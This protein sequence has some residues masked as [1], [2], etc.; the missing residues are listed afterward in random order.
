MTGSSSDVDLSDKNGNTDTVKQNG[1]SCRSPTE[2][3]AH[4]QDPVFFFGAWFSDIAIAISLRAGAAP[5]G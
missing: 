1:S 2:S 3:L 4:A 5:S